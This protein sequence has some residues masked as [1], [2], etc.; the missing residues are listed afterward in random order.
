MKNLPHIHY[1]TYRLLVIGTA[2]FCSLAL[3][4]VFWLELPNLL[5]YY[6]FLGDASMEELRAWYPR[7]FLWIWLFYHGRFLLFAIVTVSVFLLR[8]RIAAY[9]HRLSV[10][11]YPY[12]NRYLENWSYHL[13]NMLGVLIVL[14]AFYGV[15]RWQTVEL[16]ESVFTFQQWLA[17]LF[18]IIFFGYVANM[19]RVQWPQAK[20]WWEEWLYRPGTPRTLAFFRILL[21][22][23]LVGYYAF[24][25]PHWLIWMQHNM[26]ASLPFMDWAAPFFHILLPIYPLL[27]KL[28]IAAALAICL[29]LA[30]R[31]L[32]PL[33][34]VLGLLII[35]TPNFFGKLSHDHLFIWLPWFFTFSRCADA[36]S[37]DAFWRRWNG[38]SLPVRNLAPYT[39]PIR[40]VWL[41]LAI[42]YFFPGMHKLWQSG[43][44]WALSNSMV[45]QVQMEWVQHYDRVPALRID[46]FPNLL[47]IGGLLLVL[48]ELAY[49]FLL[50]KSKTRWL[51]FIGGLLFHNL[52]GYFMYIGFYH[53]QG[54]YLFLIPWERLSVFRDDELSAS[55]DPRPTM[56]TP[57]VLKAGLVILSLNFFCGLF[58]IHSMPFS[59]YP[60]Y[61]NLVASE[62]ELLHFEGYLEDGT[63]IDVLAH[64]RAAGFRREDCTVYENQI[65]AEWQAGREINAQVQQYWNLWCAKAPI[66]Q[67]I[68]HLKVFYQRTPVAPEQRDVLIH[69]DLLYE[70]RLR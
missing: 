12:S 48:F 58:F 56:S 40:L 4:L 50:L 20:N 3:C 52:A 51:A 47:K 49:P 55:T 65:I 57:L 38:K 2:F 5:Q 28:G 44:D 23:F 69:Q 10:L 36:W 70:A 54:I 25:G 66:L 45:H 22:G 42:I 39:I 30:T 32:L 11:R 7:F 26:P 16:G 63:A 6:A 24:Q 68:I 21:F 62:I 60:T 33:H 34:A 64:A 17:R 9:L 46:H 61:S 41:S 59:A 14:L 43:F 1:L 19:L 31:F 15:G 35:A 29:G 53:L 13:I 37:L 18:I 67:E 8:A 27:C